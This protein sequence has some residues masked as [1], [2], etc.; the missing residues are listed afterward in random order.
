MLIELESVHNRGIT[1]FLNGL[2]SSP[3][4][5]MD[6]VSASHNGVF[7]PDYVVDERGRLMELR[8]DR[9]LEL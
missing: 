4:M 3:L 6:A 9:I 8:F 1:I 5:V 2:P 7:M